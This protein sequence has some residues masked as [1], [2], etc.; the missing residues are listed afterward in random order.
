[1]VRVTA[2]P[3]AARVETLSTE[4]MY[5][6]PAENSAVYALWPPQLVGLPHAPNVPHSVPARTSRTV[7]KGPLPQVEIS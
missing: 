4:M 3:A 6:V 7:V 2:P 1:M 5:V